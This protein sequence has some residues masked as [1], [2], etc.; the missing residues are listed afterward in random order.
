MVLF[1]FF[2]GLWCLWKEKVEKDNSIR[3]I[4]KNV[5]KV[6]MGKNVANAKM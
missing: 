1:F 4:D 5:E 6:G 3:A 2:S